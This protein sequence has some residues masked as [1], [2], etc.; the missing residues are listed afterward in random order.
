ML[1]MFLFIYSTVGTEELEEVG[2]KRKQLSVF[3]VVKFPNDVVSARS[4]V[5]NESLYSI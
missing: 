3:T 4:M 1:F 5:N 2:R